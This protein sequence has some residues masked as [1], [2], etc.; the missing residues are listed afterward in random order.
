MCVYV[1]MYCVLCSV[2]L[3]STVYLDEGEIERWYWRISVLC[4]R[5]FFVWSGC[6]RR[7]IWALVWNGCWIESHQQHICSQSTPSQYHII[8][9]RRSHT[10]YHDHTITANHQ[11]QHNHHITLSTFSLLSVSLQHFAQFTTPASHSASLCLISE[12]SHISPWSIRVFLNGDPTTSRTDSKC[13]KLF[14]L[15][16]VSLGKLFSNVWDCWPHAQPFFFPQAW[17]RHWQ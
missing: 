10:Y 1:C 17:D 2:V 3:N 9:S 16:S 11:K 14:I 5:S 8:H 15:V 13:F 4:C 6:L 7:W 12:E